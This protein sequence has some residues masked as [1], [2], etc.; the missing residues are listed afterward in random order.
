MA[1]RFQFNRTKAVAALLFLAS[2]QPK[3]VSTFDR[4]KAAKLLFLADKLHLVRYGRPITGDHYKALQWG[5]IPQSVLDTLSELES[6]TFHTLTAIAASEVLEFQ[7]IEG[8]GHPCLIPKGRLDER[9]LS[10]SD[11][12]ALNYVA[13]RFGRASFD[14]LY[15]VTH[16]TPAYQKAWE[17]RG[18]AA[19]S[20]MDFKDFFQADPDAIDGVLQELVEDDRLRNAL[21]DW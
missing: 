16:A 7:S 17:K 8:H 6:G 18:G 3:R 12:E 19:A 9:A 1:V 11:L 15:R 2:Q 5:P 20:E 13:D 4:Y 14:E 10:E 21:T